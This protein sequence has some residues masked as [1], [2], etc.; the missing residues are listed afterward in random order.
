MEATVTSNLSIITSR[1]IPYAYLQHLTE[2]TTHLFEKSFFSEYRYQ[3]S[4]AYLYYS[5]APILVSQLYGK[6][7]IKVDM[8]IEPS[9]VK[10]KNVCCHWLAIK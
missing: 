7:E 10:S 2:H 8:E 9:K 4:K 6:M 1:Y 5:L 3:S